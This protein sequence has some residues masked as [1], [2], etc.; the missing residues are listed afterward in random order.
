MA[1]EEKPTL[2][3]F[4]IPWKGEKAKVT[5][6]KFTYGERNDV[7]RECSEFKLTGGQEIF[8]MDPFKLQEISI[9]KAL[10]KAPFEKSIDAIRMLD[11]SIGDLIYSEVDKLNR[12]S[13][14]KKSS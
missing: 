1:I 2:K 14:L 10:V 9:L 3:E 4:D 11:P 12:I 13:E 5:I 6:K 7:R 8:R